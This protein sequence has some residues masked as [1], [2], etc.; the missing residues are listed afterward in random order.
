MKTMMSNTRKNR[1]NPSKLLVLLLYGTYPYLDVES[2]EG[3]SKRLTMH[4]GKFA[5]LMRVRNAHIIEYLGWLEQM[6]FITIV[7]Q[8]R[9][10]ITIVLD[11]PTLFRNAI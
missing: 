8:D 4:V 11:T 3:S 5:K 2:T 6:N 10:T 7:N 9:Y 1:L